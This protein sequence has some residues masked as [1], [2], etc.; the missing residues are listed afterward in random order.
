VVLSDAT[1]AR[2]LAEG[3]IEIDPYDEALLQPSSV[4]VRCDRLFRVF[5]NNRYP[6]ID[7]KVEQAELTELVRVEDEEMEG[8]E[9]V[10][11]VEKPG[12]IDI[13]LQ[14]QSYDVEWFNPINGEVVELKKF[15]ADR[16][17]G[18]PPDRSHDWVLHI[19][20]EARKQSMRSYKFESSRIIMQEVE[21][22]PQKIPYEIAEPA[23]DSISLSKPA[24]YAVKLTRETKATRNMM[25][26]WTGEVPA[27]Q[28]GVRVIGTGAQG[29]FQIP[30]NLTNTYPANLAVRLYGLNALGKVYS[31][32]RVYQLSQ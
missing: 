1:I 15:K 26:L 7:V 5:H 20:R 16:F 25:W 24:R 19:S 11:Y 2:F 31:L 17:S 14:K 30:A 27:D 10:V 29:T 28:Q 13:V 4:D 32:I 9:Y 6:Y 3:R 8:I 18:E 23:S 12:P 22:I 21:Q